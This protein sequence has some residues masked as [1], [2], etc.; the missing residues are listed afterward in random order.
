MTTEPLSEPDD[1]RR[2]YELDGWMHQPTAAWWFTLVEQLPAD[3]EWY[4]VPNLGG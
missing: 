2:A 3:D 1:C 4:R